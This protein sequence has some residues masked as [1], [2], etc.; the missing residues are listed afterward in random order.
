[1][2]ILMDMEK[3]VAGGMTLMEKFWCDYPICHQIKVILIGKHY[4]RVSY[5][6]T[7]NTMICFPNAR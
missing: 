1:M 6:Q 7:L 3:Q 5:K 2:G 4:L